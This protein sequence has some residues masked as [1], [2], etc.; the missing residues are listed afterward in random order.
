MKPGDLIEWVYVSHESQNR[1]ALDV[2]DVVIDNEI[3]SVPMQAWIP[4][5][6][7]ALLVGLA[8]GNMTWVSS[9]GLFHAQ[10]HDEVSVTA[11]RPGEDL[12]NR[13]IA[14]VCNQYTRV[15]ISRHKR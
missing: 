14:R 3:W 9:V 11:M 7:V 12:V 5:R 15:Q 4:I 1:H 2:L 10:I 13:V 6:G 8:E